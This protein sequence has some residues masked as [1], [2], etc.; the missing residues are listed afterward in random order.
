MPRAVFAIADPGDGDQRRGK[1]E[2]SKGNIVD[3]DRIIEDY[4]ADTARLFMLFASP[5]DKDLDW[6]DK[7]VEGCYRFINRVWRIIYKYKDLYVQ[8]VQLDGLVL[9]D[10]LRAL[11]IEL[12]RAV[13]IV[14]NDIEERMQYNTA[15]AR[16]MELVNALYQTPE[17]ELAT[18]AGKMVLS[19]VVS[20]LILMLSPFIPHVAEE[21]WEALGNREMLVHAAWPEYLEEYTVRAEVEVVFQI[22][23]KIR[24]KTRVPADISK[25]QLVTMAESDERIREILKG[26]EIIKTIVVPGKLVNYVIKQ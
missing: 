2:Q 10:A 20:K 11:R 8:N 9:S 12:H 7:G 26:R 23:G 13:K 3:P 1:D 4:G 14:T 15:I 5:P 18:A 25:E 24:S 6:S 19:E 22:N 17:S 16:L 21:L